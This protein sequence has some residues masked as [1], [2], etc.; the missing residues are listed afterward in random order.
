MMIGLSRLPAAALASLLG[1]PVFAF[2]PEFNGNAAVTV[3]LQE[4]LTNYELPIGPFQAGQM[5]TRNV[6]GLMDQT[7]WRITLSDLT[8]LSILVPLR[9]Q[10]SQE[11]WVVVY[12]CETDAC[13]GF[14]FRY[15]TNVLPEPDM[16]VD[17]A[18]FRFLAAEQNGPTGKE[19]L[20]LMISRSTEAGFV[21]LIRIGADLPQPIEPLS[22]AA[23]PAPTTPLLTPEPDL[24]DIGSRLETGGSIALD[25]LI[26][27]SGSATLANGDYPSLAALA[28]YLTAN[29]ARRITLVGHTDASGGLAANVALS[30]KRATSVRDRLIA[31]FAVDQGQVDA[32]GVGYLSPRASNLTPE[33]RTAN[34]RVEVM[35]TSTQ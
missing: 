33:G 1:W 14:D 28:A 24:A 13:G 6:E 25:D 17:L 5:Q 30:K 10:L 7:A 15:G 23:P 34:R 29:P 12:E 4:G 3:N 21:Q 2:N 16:H 19:Y 26:F 8:T 20:S 22:T 18:D 9:E 31:A 35:L 27:P 32:E 11:G